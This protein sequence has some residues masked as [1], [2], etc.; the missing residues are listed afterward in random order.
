VSTDLAQGGGPMERGWR[1][2]TD[3]VAWLQKNL[4]MSAKNLLDFGLE[5]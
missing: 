5:E 4:F 2:I 3:L 1:W